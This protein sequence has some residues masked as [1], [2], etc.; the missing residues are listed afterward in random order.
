MRAF[1]IHLR[2]DERKH[3]S[4]QSLANWRRE[5]GAREGRFVAEIYDRPNGACALNQ[6]PSPLL[7]ELS[8]G[9][10]NSGTP[11]PPTPESESESEWR[12]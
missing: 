5:R 8:P 6:S 1:P 11:L 2:E 9:R 4:R 3:G 12:T 7:A 10:P